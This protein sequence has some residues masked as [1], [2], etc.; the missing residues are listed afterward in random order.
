MPWPDSK[1]SSS[2]NVSPTSSMSKITHAQVCTRQFAAL[3]CEQSTPSNFYCTDIETT[4]SSGQSLLRGICSSFAG[5]GECCVNDQ[6][7]F[8]WTCFDEPKKNE[9][10]LLS[11]SDIIIVAVGGGT[12]YSL[13]CYCV[14]TFDT[15]RSNQQKPFQPQKSLTQSSESGPRNPRQKVKFPKS[16]FCNSLKS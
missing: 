8:V 5:Y 14:P 4:C 13:F 3:D 12:F 15:E 1:R 16:F 2:I 6:S 11:D 7:A 10:S 9:D